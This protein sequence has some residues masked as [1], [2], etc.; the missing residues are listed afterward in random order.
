MSLYLH[1]N[2]MMKADMVLVPTKM[3]ASVSKTEAMTLLTSL[4]LYKGKVI[5]GK[6]KTEDHICK[7]RKFK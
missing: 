5:T 7:V 4:I 2:M 3:W 6:P 1:R